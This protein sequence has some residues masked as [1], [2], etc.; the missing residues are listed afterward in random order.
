MAAGMTE[1][2]DPARLVDGLGS[3]WALA[4]T[5]FKYHAACRHTHPAADA[6][7]DLMQR[8]RLEADAIERVV[9][10]VHQGA[11]DVLGVVGEPATIHQ[12]KFSMGTVLG[13]IAHGGLAGLNDFERALE[14]PEVAA[15]RQRVEMALDPEVDAAYPERWIGKVTV[16]L[17]DGG[18]LA[19]RVNEPKGDPGNSLSREEIEA[20]VRS[21]AAFGGDIEPA[22]LDR[23]IPKLWGIAEIPVVG[24]LL[25]RAS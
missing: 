25:Q 9:A 21:L 11:I 6:L 19:G 3:R 17:K 10:E 22:E 14:R 8:E 7:R 16:H 5:S 18:T 2:A 4:E 24:M 23:L 15:F 20:K 1:H 12:A 13:L